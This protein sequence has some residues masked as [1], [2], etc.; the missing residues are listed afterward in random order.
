MNGVSSLNTQFS[1]PTA[2]VGGWVSE[3]DRE[4]L[5]TM[6]CIVSSFV[7]ASLSEGKANTVL[8]PLGREKW[9]ILLKS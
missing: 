2:A 9:V 6:S 4:E 7:E 5:S 3:E 1:H 8:F